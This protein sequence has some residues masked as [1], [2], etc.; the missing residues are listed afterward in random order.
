M[1][2]VAALAA[3]LTPSGGDPS[4]RS[5]SILL[6]YRLNPGESLRYKLSADIQGSVPLLDPSGPSEL[7]ASIAVTYI[8]MPKTRLAD[9][10]MDV[11]FKVEKAELTIEKIPFPI[12]DEQAQQVLNQTVTLASTGEVKH[13]AGCAPAPFSISVP[14]VDPKRLYA[15]VFPVVFQARP[16]RAGDSWRYK[17][18]LLGGPGSNP[19]FT[20][21]L[22]P[23]DPGATA[24]ARPA[25]RKHADPPDGSGTTATSVL[26]EDFVM[27][28]DQKVDADHKPVTDDS[29]AHRARHGRISGTGTFAFDRTAGRMTHGTVDIKA[30]VQ[31]D[32]LAKPEPADEPK[33]LVSKIDAKVRIDLEPQAEAPGSGAAPEAK[34]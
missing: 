14:G 26:R 30:D 29:K 34:P 33:Q 20:A 32:L 22:L 2:P 9:G 5:A 4:P 18:E 24:A 10:T 1:L 17:S 23:A 7:H 28:V 12:P 16:V 15:L 8:A 21:T 19:T 27:P 6:A 31:D 25:H 13:V 11:D 3:L